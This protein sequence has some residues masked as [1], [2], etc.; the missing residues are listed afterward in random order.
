MKIFATEIEPRLICKINNRYEYYMIL[1][2]DEI[3]NESIT[4]MMIIKTHLNYTINAT[5]I[6]QISFIFWQNC[7]IMMIHPNTR[8]SVGFLHQMQQ[9]DNNNSS[10]RKQI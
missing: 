10:E 7:N 3:E 6:Y 4:I 2:I 9:H 5:F 1:V 8:C